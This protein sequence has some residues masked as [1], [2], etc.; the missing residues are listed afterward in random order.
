[1]IFQFK[2]VILKGDKLNFNFQ[3]KQ[4]NKRKSMTNNPL[5]HLL[6]F[7]LTISLIT[8][9]TLA[10]LTP[11]TITSS[12]N[13]YYYD[14]KHK[15]K[16]GFLGGGINQQ[17]TKD[18]T[19]QVKSLLK[20]KHITLTSN[21]INQVASDIEALKTEINTK[22]LNLI[23]KKD[24]DYENHFKHTTGFITQTISTKGHIK[25]K[26]ITSQIKT[27]KLILNDK[28]ITN[29]LTPLQN[30][31]K[32]QID[33]KL[34]KELNT[35]SILKLLSSKYKLN[36]KEINQ[37]RA[38]LNNKEWDESH[39]SLTKLGSLIVA[40]TVSA[41][42]QGAGSSIVSSTTSTQ[43]ASFTTTQAIASASTQAVVNSLATQIATAAI[44]GEKFKLDT[45]S[46]VKSAVSAGVLKGVGG[47]LDSAQGIKGIKYSNLSL[48]QKIIKGITHATL[49]AGVNKAIY[50]TNFKDSLKSNLATQ[51]TNIGFSYVGDYSQ[52]QE[53]NENNSYFQEG[54]IGKV[55]LHSIIGGIGAKLSGGE[56]KTGALSAGARELISPLTQ[57]ESQTTQLA[58][59]QLTGALVGYA[60]N[61]DKGAQTG[62]NISTSAEEYNRQLHEKEI[63]F[64]KKNALSFA[65]KR[66]NTSNP[67]KTQIQEAT[68]L[69]YTS[70]MYYNDKSSKLWIDANQK[71]VGYPYSKQDIRKAFSFLQENSKDKTFIDVYKNNFQ[72][73]NYFT[74]TSEQ[75]NTSSYTP[76]TTIGLKD[77]SVDT[78]LFLKGF[79]GTIEK[80]VGKIGEDTRYSFNK[81]LDDTLNIK[82]NP[83]DGTEKGNLLNK[84]PNGGK[85]SLTKYNTIDNKPI[86]KRDNG[87][88][89]IYD[90]S[91]KQVGV[92]SPKPKTTFQ[93]KPYAKHRPPHK[94]STVNQV[95]ENAKEKNRNGKVIDP[96]TKEEITW[97][98]TQPRNGQWDMG[99]RDETYKKLHDRYMD[100]EI[101][102]EEFLK[103]FHDPNNYHPQ[104]VNSNRSRRHDEK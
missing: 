41:L 82:I 50:N 21:K 104:T 73:Q 38:I 45:K 74:S 40:I 33:K 10:N 66:F 60:L 32:E 88:Y 48:S 37:A 39:T 93:N 25:E 16:G 24:T 96:Y 85:V 42:T 72:Q 28:D 90:D 17:D 89:F 99:H 62:Y 63:E 19:T 8:T 18:T 70:A 9:N 76:D 56:F 27:N 55:A 71:E 94:Q 91:G 35:N 79:G 77:E 20:A 6:S 81:S 54:G 29:K 22:V 86:F 7:I 34:S 23:S 97:D 69:L 84:G 46:L 87:E 2:R 83:L 53:L 102:K 14:L 101:T 80:S 64:I 47:A 98:K 52:H 15:V 36:Q 68:K 61:G 43:V 5:K 44:T 95:W 65:K 49:N 31:I 12:T 30:D 67:T 57:G 92:N 59:S 78:L 75:Y 51:A 13:R 3:L 26:E 11:I 103:E 1:M 4:N 100:D 58:L